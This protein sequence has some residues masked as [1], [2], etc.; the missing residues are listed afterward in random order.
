M[1]RSP[2]ERMSPL[3]V[4]PPAPTATVRLPVDCS[5]PLLETVPPDTVPAPLPTVS[6]ATAMTAP[7]RLLRGPE[8]FTFVK[9]LAPPMILPLLSMP[10]TSMFRPL[11]IS[12]AFL[13]LVKAVVAP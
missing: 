5:V 2:S 13:S 8:A 3:L 12:V 1:C 4:S 6:V 7:L 9:A 11:P 10:A